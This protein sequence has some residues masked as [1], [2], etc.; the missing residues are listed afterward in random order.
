MIHYR[1]KSLTLLFSLLIACSISAVQRAYADS[2]RDSAS[3]LGEIQYDEYSV[4]KKVD[5]SSFSFKPRVLQSA[6]LFP[7]PFYIGNSN[8]AVFKKRIFQYY[9]NAQHKKFVIRSK[10]TF[11]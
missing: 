10:G 8:H 6:G 2:P 9:Q 1:R 7:S 4:F 5:S 11:F 3:S